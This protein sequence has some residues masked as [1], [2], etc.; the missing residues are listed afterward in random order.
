MRALLAVV[1]LALV[2]AGC[3][4]RVT[5][6]P[7][8]GERV[9]VAVRVNDAR[10]VR[11]QAFLQSAVARAVEDRMG[12]TVAPDGS[13]R[14]DLA[15]AEEDIDRTVSDARDVPIRWRITV[16]GTAALTAARGHAVGSF[17]GSGYASGLAGESE[18][19]SDAADKA[20]AEVAVWLERAT[21][22]WK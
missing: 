13:A 21:A 17:H 16:T 8:L 11:V 15:I 7:A 5:A 14:L 19:L 3:S 18:A 4:Y 20:A 1:A 9:R 22:D 6:P 10:L 2:G 12:W